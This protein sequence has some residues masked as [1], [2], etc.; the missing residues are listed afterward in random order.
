VLDRLLILVVAGA[1]A[2][3]ASAQ[4]GDWR[5]PF[6][7]TPEDVVERMLVLA[8][9]GSQ[10]LVLDLGSGDGRIVIAAARR[11]G[12]QG[13]G[14]DFDARL[15]A[16]AREN[17][18]SAGVADRVRFLQDDVLRADISRASVVTVY[19]LPELLW[20][21]QARFISELEPGTRI[22]SHAFQMSGWRPDRM[23]TLRV[24][25]PHPGQGE[26]STLYLWIVPAN[27]RG[28]WQNGA[29]RIRIAQN[30][31]EIE[32]EGASRAAIH[33]RDIT[34]ESAHGR[35]SGRIE[36]E[37]IVGHQEDRAGARTVTFVRAR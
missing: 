9:T 10:D 24:R 2:L 37:H 35:F 25:S 11:F 28:T 4:D 7:R 31:Q 27:V 5:A 19:L 34:W 36:G 8:G 6:I 22:V 1:C 32:V 26:T 33:G 20:K 13:L 30:Y 21:L 29:D 3:S 18:R 14:I 23:E 16:A 17:A 15:V 12:A